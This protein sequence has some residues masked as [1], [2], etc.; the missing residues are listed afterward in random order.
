MPAERRSRSHPFSRWFLEEARIGMTESKIIDGKAFAEG[1]R[2]RIAAEVQG[3]KAAK[4]IVPGL[5]VVLVGENPASQVYVRNKARQTKDV[6]MNSW[7]HRLDASPSQADLLALIARLNGD[8]EVDGILV[9]LPLPKHIDSSL[10]LDAIDPTKDV[11][12]FH[13]VNVGRL[14]AGLPGLVP[15][16]P[17]G[18]LMLLKDRLGDLSGKRALVLGRS[19][20]VGKPVAQLLL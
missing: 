14:A 10:V 17:L 18:C 12:G 5:A 4:N 6:G 8:P 16:T 20:I 7:E 13:V 9:Q 19:N 2:R 1:M 15:C 3:I 11:D